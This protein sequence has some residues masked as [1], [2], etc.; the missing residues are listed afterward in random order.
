VRL[1]AYAKR[2]GAALGE[3]GKQIGP[4]EDVPEMPKRRPRG[5]QKE[6][7]DFAA[8][9]AAQGATLLSEMDARQKAQTD[10]EG[11]KP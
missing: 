8:R 10:G 6:A 11:A 4:P 9:T 1:N 2:C 7:A 3:C 5:G